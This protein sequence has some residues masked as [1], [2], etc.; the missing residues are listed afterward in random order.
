MCRRGPCLAAARSARTCPPAAEQRGS[1][2]VCARAC[3]RACVLHCTKALRR[4]VPPG[5]PGSEQCNTRS[6][7][8]LHACMHAEHQLPRAAPAIA[9]RVTGEAPMA[10]KQ[11]ATLPRISG[12]ARSI[13][14]P[15]MPRHLGPTCPPPLKRVARVKFTWSCRRRR[16]R[17]GAARTAPQTPQTSSRRCTRCCPPAPCCC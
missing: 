17:A 15:D 13:K 14:F 4:S 3:V 5:C 8:P 16:C 11:S 9:D 12:W 7:P 1:V 2:C 6:T 10:R